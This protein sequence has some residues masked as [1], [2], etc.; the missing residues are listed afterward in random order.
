M[1][2]LATAATV[3]ASQAVI[4]GAVSV[5]HQAVQLGYLPRL[6]INH[7]SAQTIGQIYVPWIN[8]LLMGS[9]LTLVLAFRTSTALAYTFGMAVTGTITITTILLFYVAWQA[10]RVPRWALALAAVVLLGTDL[11]FVAANLTKL[12][13]GAWLPLFIAV[14]AFTVMT[15]W[16]RGRKLLAGKREAMEGSLRAFVDGLRTGPTS[17]QVVSGTAIFLNRGSVTAPLA[18][19]AN[20]EHN[21]VRHEQV[22]VVTVQIE[23]VPR[24]ADALRV[25]I[26]HLGEPDDGIA[27]VTVRF[28]YDERPNVPAA[29]AELGPDQTE[30][31]LDLGSATYF[32]SRIELGL[33]DKPGM[34]AWRRHLFIATSYIAADAAEQ[35]GLPHDRTVVLGSRVD[36]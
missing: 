20:V 2:L 12:V 10:W 25:T 18:F 22:V 4:T 23:T 34:V 8:W 28:G 32:L 5:S 15:T 3:I 16:R 1:V 19:R 14:A 9:V 33:G 31:R 27:Q 21:H 30:G 29:L 7:T 6:R 24:V 35:F 17:V 13:H 26:E 11:L 36:L